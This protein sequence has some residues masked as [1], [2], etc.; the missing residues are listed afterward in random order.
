MKIGLCQVIPTQDMSHEE[1][2]HDWK[3]LM[4]SMKK[5]ILNFNKSDAM[6]ITVNDYILQ[7]VFHMVKSS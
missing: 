2:P 6:S 4:G 3:S 5:I 1:Y 7:V